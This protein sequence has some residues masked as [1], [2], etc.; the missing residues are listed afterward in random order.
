[1]KRVTIDFSDQPRLL[2]GKLLFDLGLPL[3]PGNTPRYVQDL[4]GVKPQSVTSVRDRSTQKYKL[5]EYEMD[6]TF[7]EFDRLCYLE[8]ELRSSHEGANILDL[9]DIAEPIDTT[10]AGH[11]D[12]GQGRKLSKD[13]IDL[14]QEF[15]NGGSVAR[16]SWI[17]IPMISEDFVIAKLFGLR[18]P[19]L[20]YDLESAMRRLESKSVLPEAAVPIFEAFSDALL[21]EVLC[22]GVIIYVMPGHSI[23]RVFE[24]YAEMRMALSF[25]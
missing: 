2:L 12:L 25:D 14:L 22:S 7:D 19:T 1:M 17:P 10:L 11:L 23:M 13:H 9:T 16:H 4:L 8:I 18:H 3:L 6:G 5:G 20:D 15:G 24:S 21:C